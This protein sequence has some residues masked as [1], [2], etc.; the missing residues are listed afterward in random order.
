MQSLHT[1]SYTTTHYCTAPHYTTLHCTALHYYTTLHY[2]AALHYTTLPRPAANHGEGEARDEQRVQSSVPQCSHPSPPLRCTPPI[3]PALHCTPIRPALHSMPAWPACSPQRSHQRS[4]VGCSGAE[5]TAGRCCSGPRRERTAGCH[6][7]QRGVAQ[8]S[9][10][11][12]TQHTGQHAAQHTGCSV[13]TVQWG[14][15]QGAGRRARAAPCAAGL[16]AHHCRARCEPCALR[17]ADHAGGAGALPAHGVS[18]RP[19]GTGAGAGRRRGTHRGGTRAAEGCPWRAGR[20]LRGRAACR[21][22]AR[23]AACRSAGSAPTLR[24]TDTQ[25]HPRRPWGHG[26]AMGRPGGGGVTRRPHGGGPAAYAPHAHPQRHTTR[27]AQQRGC[28][29]WMGAACG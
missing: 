6:A 8:R 3:R 10:Q 11:V 14:A 21:C 20:S 15:A 13:H 29:V 26:A 22:A 4:G 2:C 1:R 12:S 18:Q 7:V 5:R 24:P 9:T 23:L 27:G 28:I 17:V 19:R 25:G 16:R